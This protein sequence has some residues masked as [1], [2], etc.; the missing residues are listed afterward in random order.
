MYELKA[1]EKATPVVVYT[2]DTLIHGEIVTRDIVRVNILMRTEGAP[3]YLHLLNAQIIHPDNA[4]KIVKFAE[5]FVPATEVIG[6]HI[7]PGTEVELDYDKHEENRRM[8]AVKVVM[9]SFFI[10]SK[11]RIST[12]TDLGTTLDVSRTAWL[13]LYEAQ[14]TNT[15]LVQMNVPAEM[16]LIRPEKISFGLI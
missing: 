5:L 4:T 6:F 13:S 9:G 10:D 16:I 7:A 15:Y 2:E 1:N 12:H 14:I 3:N 11:I 8:Q